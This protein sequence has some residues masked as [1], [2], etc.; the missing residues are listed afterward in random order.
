MV[1]AVDF[2][3]TLFTNAWPNIGEPIWPIIKYCKRRK[4][5]GDTLILWTC[6]S[7]KDLKEAVAAC[8]S[9][10]LTFDYV[11]DNTDE[12]KA[13]YRGHVRSNRKI[14]ADLYIDDKAISTTQL[15]KNLG[16]NERHVEI[17][18]ETN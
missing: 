6:R 3:G 9:V 4:L 2:D 12:N 7:K 14:N 16:D 11:N 17:K 5:L 13:K 8:E 1:I 15:I 10:G 18:E